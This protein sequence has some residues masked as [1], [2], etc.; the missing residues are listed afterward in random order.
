MV[1]LTSLVKKMNVSTLPTQKDASPFTR[2]DFMGQECDDSINFDKLQIETQ[3][4][5]IYYHFQ[6]EKPYQENT[7]IV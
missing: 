6:K 3:N 5:S 1:G 2:Q 7:L 4:S